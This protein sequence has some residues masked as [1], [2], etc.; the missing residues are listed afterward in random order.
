MLRNL[1][2]R[3]TENVLE[4]TN[5]ER[6]LREQMQDAKPGSIAKALVDLNEIGGH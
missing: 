1:Y 5:A 3:L 6:R 2:L 4:M